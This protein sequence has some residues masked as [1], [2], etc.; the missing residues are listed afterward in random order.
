MAMLRATV[1]RFPGREEREGKSSWQAVGETQPDFYL[2]HPVLMPKRRTSLA[3]LSVPE[4][5]KGESRIFKYD[6]LDPSVLNNQLQ[7]VEPGGRSATSKNQTGHDVLD[8]C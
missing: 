3:A 5:K 1:A 8:G 6:R 7:E 2:R 4:E